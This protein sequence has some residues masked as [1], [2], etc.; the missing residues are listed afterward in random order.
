[1]D[2]VSYSVCVFTFLD[3]EVC[4]EMNTRGF[5]YMCVYECIHVRRITAE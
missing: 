4:V 1:M 2:L 5:I 3:M